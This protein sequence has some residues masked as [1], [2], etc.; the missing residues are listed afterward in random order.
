MFCLPGPVPPFYGRR[1]DASFVSDPSLTMG[2]SG[3]AVTQDVLPIT[4]PRDGHRTQDC[5]QNLSLKESNMKTVTGEHD[6]GRDYVLVSCPMDSW[7]L[8]LSE[9]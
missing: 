6:S 7:F 4:Q 8:I 1:F 2:R 9:N 3:G 5:S